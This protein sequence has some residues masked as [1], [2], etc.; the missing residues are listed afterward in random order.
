MVEPKAKKKYNTKK[1]KDVVMEKLVIAAQTTVGNELRDEEAQSLK[2]LVEE[3]IKHVSRKSK[4][5]KMGKDEVGSSKAKA[6]ERT[7][8]PI[9]QR[10][11]LDK[12]SVGSPVKTPHNSL[13]AKGEGKFLN[14]LW[15]PMSMLTSTPRNQVET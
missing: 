1:E 13:K 6:H 5:K 8:S 4:K 9:K 14:Q 3:A 11:G 2:D 10:K 15:N 7:L 12:V